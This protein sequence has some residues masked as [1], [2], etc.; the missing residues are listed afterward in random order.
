VLAFVPILFPIETPAQTFTVLYAFKGGGDGAFPRGGVVRDDAGNLYGTT[1]E[2]GSFNFGTVF[3]LDTVGV[4]TVLHN[5]VGGSDGRYP[6]AGLLLD[7][8]GNLYGTTRYGGT[9]SCFDGFALGCGT[10]YE[11]DVNGTETVLHS[12][13]GPDGKYPWAKLVKD[14]S[15]NLYGTTQQGGAFHV[16]TVFK[17]NTLGIVTVLHSFLGA[18][19]DGAYPVAELLRDTSGNLYGTTEAGG[20]LGCRLAIGPRGCGIVFKLDPNGQ[21]H[22]L[23]SFAT[24]PSGMFPSA[25]LISDPAGNLYSTAGMGGTGGNGIVFRLDRV[26]NLSVLHSFTGTDVNGDGAQPYAKPVRDAA[27]N[28]Y[29]T[30]WSGGEVPGAGTIFKIDRSGNETVLFSFGTGNGDSGQNPAAGVIL[31]SDGNLYGTTFEG[32]AHGS[33]TVFQFTP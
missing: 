23:H 26:G 17:L 22:I 33:G 20:S 16:G 3:K 28:L 14:S 12:F 18:P 13:N 19:S 30:T 25:G 4:E 7:A 1:E 31:G 2:G 15:G 32:G 8:Q 27:G 29:G 24:F 21:E 11:L 5:F 6:E 10:V 9:G